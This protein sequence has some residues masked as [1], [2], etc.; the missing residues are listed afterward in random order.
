MKQLSVEPRR[1]LRVVQRGRTLG[2]RGGVRPAS[3]EL[4]STTLLQKRSGEHR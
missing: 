3:G 4:A 2:L 1:E